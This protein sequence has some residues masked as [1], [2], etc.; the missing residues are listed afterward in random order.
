MTD[1]NATLRAELERAHDALDKAYKER[2]ALR[3]NMEKAT[4]VLHWFESQRESAINRAS[5]TAPEDDAVKRLCD[6]HG[7]GAVMDSAARQWTK[8][9][10]SGAFFIGGCV[11]DTSALAAYR[12]ARKD[13]A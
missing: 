9:D 8:M 2:D 6:R 4:E 3:A 7:Y 11:G 10:G 1:E 5:I 12:A 13:Q